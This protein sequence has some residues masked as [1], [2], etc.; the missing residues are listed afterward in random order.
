MWAY[1]DDPALYSALAVKPRIPCGETCQR[2]RPAF[3]FSDP[4]LDEKWGDYH[5]FEVSQ[6]EPQEFPSPIRIFA[7]SGNVTATAK[8]VSEFEAKRPEIL[9]FLE[10]LTG[11]H[12]GDLD[13]VVD[14][15]ALNKTPVNNY[16]GVYGFR[17]PVPMA[18]LPE[19]VFQNLSRQPE[20]LTNQYIGEATLTADG[21]S[22][23]FR[24]G[25][26]TLNG[27]GYVLRAEPAG[28]IE[29]NGEDLDFEAGQE[30]EF[31]ERLTEI[32]EQNGLPVPDP[33]A[34]HVSGAIC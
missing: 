24:L 2:E 6:S 10:N 14:A 3:N 26:K 19:R 15:M 20:L 8:S 12:R 21:W 31:R 9:A 7:T 27:P 22:F 30:E 33:E 13:P 29:F 16:R 32:L 1:W 34:I 11:A 5:L 25:V 4:T 23:V 18:M 17:A 28:Q